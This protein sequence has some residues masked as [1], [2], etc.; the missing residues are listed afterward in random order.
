MTSVETN[1]YI[2]FVIHVVFKAKKA[3]L[4]AVTLFVLQNS[5]V[6]TIYGILIYIF[7]SIKIILY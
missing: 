4:N 6:G 5:A 7:T 1:R 3:L 2:V